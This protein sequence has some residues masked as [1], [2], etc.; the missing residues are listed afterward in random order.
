MEILEELED[1]I[2]ERKRDEWRAKG[3]LYPNRYTERL[4]LSGMK[5]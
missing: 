3:V 2:V 1:V 4:Y 5:R